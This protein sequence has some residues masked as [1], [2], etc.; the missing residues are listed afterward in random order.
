MSGWLGVEF[1]TVKAQLS[2]QL[3]GSVYAGN[4]LVGLVYSASLP[5]VSYCRHCDTQQ[6]RR[7]HSSQ[8]SRAMYTT[9]RNSKEMIGM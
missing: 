6:C 9:K 8:S 1:E 4:E 3:N 5:G 2:K 7:R